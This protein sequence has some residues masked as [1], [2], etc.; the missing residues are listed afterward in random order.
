MLTFANTGMG[1][2]SFTALKSTRVFGKLPDSPSRLL[3]RISVIAVALSV[4]VMIISV[5]VLNGFRNAVTEKVIGFG[6]H[7]SVLPYSNEQSMESLPLQEG[8]ALE[9]QLKAIPG[10]VHVQEFATKACIFKANDEIEGLIYKGVAGSYDLKFFKKHLISGSIEDFVRDTSGMSVLLSKDIASKLKLKAGDKALVFFVQQP[11]RVRKLYVAGLFNTGLEDFDNRMVI[12]SM[13]LVRKLNAW[14]PATIGGIELQVSSFEESEE[15]KEAVNRNLPAECVALSIQ[16]QYPQLFDWLKLQDLNVWVILA[17]MGA[18]AIINMMTA[19]LILILENT[20]TIGLYKAL[21][22]GN[23]SIRS[24]F[25]LKA[26][27]LAT[28]G[29]IRGNIIG[30]LFLWI[31]DQFHIIALDEASYYMAWVP[32]S[33]SWWAYLWI[34]LGTWLVCFVSLVIPSALISGISPSRALSFR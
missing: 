31:Q 18:V 15:I 2:I 28:R 20:G 17:L 10:V 25:L 11:N 7:I 19:L 5:S 9:S 13:R 3:Y 29:L 27:A 23:G 4:A 24:V 33:W 6:S 32:V 22:A 30:L 1:F 12:G 14:A 21:G 34:N 8:K 26:S 16:D